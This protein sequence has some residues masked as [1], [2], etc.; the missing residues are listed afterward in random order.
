[1]HQL[2]SDQLEAM[3]GRA[4]FLTVTTPESETRCNAFGRYVVLH[5]YDSRTCSASKGRKN[6]AEALEVS[7]RPIQSCEQSQA[8]TAKGG[9]KVVYSRCRAQQSSVNSQSMDSSDSYHS[10][11]CHLASSTNTTR[12]PASLGISHFVGIQ[13]LISS[14]CR[15]V[16]DLQAG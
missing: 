14:L 6:L 12:Y 8:E 11:D 16:V 4:A 15:S 9:C 13:A 3:Q 2:G 1:M 7:F 10:M 5:L